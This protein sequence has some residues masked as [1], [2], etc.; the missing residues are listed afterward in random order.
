MPQVLP[1]LLPHGTTDARIAGAFRPALRFA[2]SARCLRLPRW[3]PFRSLACLVAVAVLLLRCFSNAF[4]CL[5]FFRCFCLCLLMVLQRCFVPVP[6][7]PNVAGC[8]MVPIA[9]SS[10]PCLAFNAF[11]ALVPLPSV[12]SRA[13]FLRSHLV[14]RS[15]ASLFLVGSLVNGQRFPSLQADLVDQ[16]GPSF[17][18]Q[19]PGVAAVLLRFFSSG[20][21]VV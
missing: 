6:L 1:C 2:V 13:F 21:L 9:A 20:F 15:P 18:G 4:R 11:V 5:R 3:F 16:R 14:L 17:L 7:L 19:Y 12:P 8:H 10:L